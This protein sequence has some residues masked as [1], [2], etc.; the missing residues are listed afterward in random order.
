MN[1]QQFFSYDNWFPGF[2]AI[3]ANIHQMAAMT[4]FVILV[5]SLVFS[6]NGGS[7]EGLLSPFLR[8]VPF[9]PGSS[10]STAMP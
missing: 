4:A 6:I 3:V 10:A 1:L 9:W 7:V 5:A 2:N 8:S